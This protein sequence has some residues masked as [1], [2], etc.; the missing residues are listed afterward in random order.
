M[1]KEELSSEVLREAAV[2]V[3]GGPREKFSA[4][5]FEALK[6]YLAGGGSVLLAMGEGGEGRFDTNVNFLLEQYGISVNADSVVRSACARS[7]APS[8]RSR[9][10][11]AYVSSPIQLCTI[12]TC[13]RRRC[14][15]RRAC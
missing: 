10:A 5:E 14:S 9:L 15:C 6:G 13:T 1:N 7:R 11:H 2:L 8:S 3:L 4:S 12:S